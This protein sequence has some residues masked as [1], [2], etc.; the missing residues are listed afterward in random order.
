MTCLGLLKYISRK[1]WSAGSKTAQ[2][3][4][5]IL[6]TCRRDEQFSRLKKLKSKLEL[7]NSRKN[8]LELELH[9]K[10]TKT[11]WISR[12][13]ERALERNTSAAC[14]DSCSYPTEGYWLWTRNCT[15]KLLNKVLCLICL[16]QVI[17]T[18]LWWRATK[19]KKRMMYHRPSLST[20]NIGSRGNKIKNSEET[21]L[22]K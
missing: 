19:R 14:K 1:P 13:N 7:I 5:S 16:I 4:V 8:H 9:S 20:P 21:S 2:F 18:K 12:R 3:S 15:K 22:N 6:K 11:G 10:W 17:K